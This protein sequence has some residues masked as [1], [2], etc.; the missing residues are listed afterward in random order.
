MTNSEY[1]HDNDEAL[2]DDDDDEAIDYEPWPMVYAGFWSRLLA[3]LIDTLVFGPLIALQWWSMSSRS[4]SLALIIPLGVAGPLYSV[5]M[6]ARRGQTLGKIVAGIQVAKVSGEPVSWRE[7]ILR[8]SVTIAFD[9]I[10][11][12]AT[13][14][15]L[16][17]I[18]EAAW[19]ANWRELAVKLHETEPTWGRWAG[20]AMQVWFWG[21]LF[22]LLLNRKR[23]SL[24]DFIAGTVVIRVAR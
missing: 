16:L 5:V 24:H 12:T 8:D 9:V 2:D 6:H 19:S 13:M 21:E 18:P 4:A 22:V 17:H 7:A 3:H 11:T 23:R 1:A 10:S 15:A 20:I 14:F